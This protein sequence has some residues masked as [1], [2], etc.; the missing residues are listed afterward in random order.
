MSRITLLSS[1]TR[2]WLTA[3]SAPLIV[4][5]PAGH[6]PSSKFAV[7]LQVL[8]MTARVA[9]CLKSKITSRP[10]LAN[11]I[12]QPADAWRFQ[13][14]DQPVTTSVWI[15]EDSP[16]EAE[17]ARR[18]LAHAFEV[19]IFADGAA[20][21]ERLANAGPPAVLL[22]DWQLPN[23]SGIEVLRFVRRSLDEMAL[24]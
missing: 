24:P 19:E 14:Q 4:R 23:M 1:T 3:D 6:K 11:A 18:P 8:G 2:I 9:I 15:V 7:G 17:M 16:L 22:L 5:F 21:L 12:N 20:M 13:N 10:L